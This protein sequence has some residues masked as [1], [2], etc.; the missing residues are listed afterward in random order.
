MGGR[1]PVRCVPLTSA[2]AVGRAGGWGRRPYGCVGTVFAAGTRVSRGAGVAVGPRRWQHR[3]VSCRSPLRFPPLRSAFPRPAPR[4]APPRPV[5]APR[6]AEISFLLLI[7][8][9]ARPPPPPPPP[10]RKSYFH[11]SGAGF[12]G[13]LRALFLTG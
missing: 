6:A 4:P 5:R 7:F 11:R 13:R 8:P 3:P 9:T 1:L 12:C 2:R 10:P